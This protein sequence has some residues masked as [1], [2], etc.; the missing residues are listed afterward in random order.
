[1]CR[2]DPQSLRGFCWDTEPQVAFENVRLVFSAFV[3]QA[4]SFPLPNRASALSK[5]RYA[6]LV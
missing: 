6:M 1:M 3:V 4:A 5:G 2:T